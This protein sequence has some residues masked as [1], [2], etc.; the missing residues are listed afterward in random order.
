MKGLIFHH[1]GNILNL[2]KLLLFIMR[3]ITSILISL[4]IVFTCSKENINRDLLKM[5]KTVRPIADYEKIFN[6]KEYSDLLKIINDMKKNYNVEIYL[7]TFFKIDKM[8]KLS[9]ENYRIFMNIVGKQSDRIFNLNRDN[10][11][12]K[13]IIVFIF[14]HN[15]RFN[16]ENKSYKMEKLLN[17]NRWEKA[18]ENIVEKYFPKYEY[19]TAFKKILEELEKELQRNTI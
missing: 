8:G 19:Y 6:Q 5:P 18:T 10:W 17:A 16:S 14:S 9:N 13:K 4:L 12:N 3:I 2:Y 11:L 7:L 1:T 15:L